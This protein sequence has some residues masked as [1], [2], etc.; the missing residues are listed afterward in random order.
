MMKIPPNKRFFSGAFNDRIY[1]TKVLAL[2][3]AALDVMYK[4]YDSFIVLDD[5]LASL[6]VEK[7]ENAEELIKDLSKN[8]R[9]FISPV[10]KVEN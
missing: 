4:D 10:M 5:P 1:K 2:R 9:L 6:D 8:G 3:F 7:I